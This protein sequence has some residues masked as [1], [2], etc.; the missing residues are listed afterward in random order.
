MIE[1]EIKEIR[2]QLRRAMNGVTS[3]SMR[4]KG[5][6]YK[7]NFG[8]PIP[9]IKQIAATHEPNAALAEALWK[10]DIREFKILATLLQPVDTFTNE[11][12]ERWIEKIH[13]LEIAEQCSKNLFSK[14]PK[15]DELAISLLFNPF[16]CQYTYIVAYRIWAEWF[17]AGHML[18]ASQKEDFMVD[19]IRTLAVE[20]VWRWLEKQ[21]VVKALKFYGRQSAKQAEEVLGLIED[22]PVDGT[23]EQQEFYNDLKFEFEYYH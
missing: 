6:H 14:L 17:A 7:L 23:P 2:I 18:T 4:E 19:A 20:G 12:A 15:A 21:A 3:T 13:Y 5:V 16:P 9:E 22:F 11:Q 10:E 1:D 8:V